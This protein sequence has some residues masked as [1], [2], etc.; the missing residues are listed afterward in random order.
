MFEQHFP[1]WLLQADQQG[2][3]TP[4]YHKQAAKSASMANF[5]IRTYMP[6]KW[7]YQN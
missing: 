1:V 5:Y 7:A 2:N 4:V 3:E 6:P